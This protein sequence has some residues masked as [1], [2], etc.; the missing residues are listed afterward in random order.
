MLDLTA[1]AVV[2]SLDDLG[3]QPA[4]LHHG[5]RAVT[6]AERVVHGHDAP[7]ANECRT[8]PPRPVKAP[9][10][11]DELAR[12]EPD[13]H[14]SRPVA[15]VA[16]GADGVDGGGLTES[17]AHQVEAVAADVPERPA[18]EGRILTDVAR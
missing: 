17:P 9:P 15:P 8:L 14:R 5:G 7:V 10:A 18:A 12:G 13:Q 2:S 1:E 4:H 3:L 11:R 16:L 6:G